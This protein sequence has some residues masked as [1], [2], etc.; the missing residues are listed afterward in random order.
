MADLEA[1]EL[2]SVHITC[3]GIKVELNRSKP[4]FESLLFFPGRKNRFKWKK[5]VGGKKKAQASS[6]PHSLLEESQA[7]KQTFLG[8]KELL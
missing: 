1:V 8:R 4:A 7:F 2:F 5:K 6:F 3:A